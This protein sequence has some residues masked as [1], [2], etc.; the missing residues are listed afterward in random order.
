MCA[1]KHSCRCHWTGIFGP[2]SI[3]ISSTSPFVHFLCAMYHAL[4]VRLSWYLF[5]FSIEYFIDFVECAVSHSLLSLLAMNVSWSFEIFGQLEMV[6]AMRTH[7]ASADAR[8]Q[9]I[10]SVNLFSSLGHFLP[11]RRTLARWV[12]TSR[13]YDDGERRK[14][15]RLL[16]LARNYL[17]SSEQWKNMNKKSSALNI[18]N[19]TKINGGHTHSLNSYV[20]DRR[21]QFFRFQ[22]I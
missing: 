15:Q 3:R 16:L 2:F 8:S 12:H 20:R 17:Y 11:T 7:I 14:F 1:T 18:D 6:Y 13:G 21:A 9:Y 10:Y 4:A 22:M 19:F 5:T